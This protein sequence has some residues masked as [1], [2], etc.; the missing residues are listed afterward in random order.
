MVQLR[1]IQTQFSAPPLNQGSQVPGGYRPYPVDD[2]DA[3][4]GRYGL[5]P[6][7]GSGGS[8][9]S[10]PTP[11][12]PTRGVR[13]PYTPP[14]MDQLFKAYLAVSEDSDVGTNQSGDR[15]W[16]RVTRRYN[17]NW[18]DGTTIFRANDEI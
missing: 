6:E 8:G 2:Q 5:A 13:T 10:T 14:E 18:P 4:D 17:E 12:P 15:F 1:V 16:W 11:P 7:P 3:P 9:G